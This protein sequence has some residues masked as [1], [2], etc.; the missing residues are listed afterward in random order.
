MLL[1]KEKRV[2]MYSKTHLDIKKTSKSLLIFQRV[3]EDQCFR[4]V[5]LLQC[6][7]ENQ[8]RIYPKFH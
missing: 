3:G 4:M 1:P 2:M 6:S 8:R 7:E 5:R